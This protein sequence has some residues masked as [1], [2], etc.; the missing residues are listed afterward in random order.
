LV[1]AAGHAVAQTPSTGPRPAAGVD[2]FASSDADDTSVQKYGAN[3]DWRYAGP[4]EFQGLRLETARFRPQGQNTTT[5]QRVYLRLAD[6]GERWSW[7]G[8]AGTD[9]RT[10]LGSLNLNNEAKFRQEYFLERE[11][12]ETPRGLSEGVYYT[13]G[14]AALDLPINDRN[15]FTV[16]AGLQDFTGKNLR[17]H[18]RVNYVHVLKSDW[19]LTAQL[20][21]RYFHSSTPGEYDY[22]SP[23][24][25]A[26]VTPVL[27]LRRYSAGWRYLLAAGIGAQK[28]AG[29]DWRRSRYLN[30]Q[31]TSPTLSKGWALTGAFTYSDTPVGSGVTYDYKQVNLGVTRVF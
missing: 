10:V 6:K 7:K 22:F 20:R 19:G 24:W 12:L 25:Y 11:I 30:A 15:N 4:D 27:Q 26:E 5:D 13:F 21:T 18:V 28:S 29:A 17:T 8:Q 3:L 2:V 14:G 23:R 16:V 31:V 9:G 1:L